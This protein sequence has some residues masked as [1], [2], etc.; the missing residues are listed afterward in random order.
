[1]NLLSGAIVLINC[2][3]SSKY[4]DDIT[5]IRG[6]RIEEHEEVNQKKAVNISIVAFLCSFVIAI[7]GYLRNCIF[8]KMEARVSGVIGFVIFIVIMVLINLF[9][10]EKNSYKL[11]KKFKY[12]KYI[13][14]TKLII[15]TSIIAII[16]NTFLLYK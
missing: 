1:M 13:K 16:I 10:S 4:L 2:I 8:L 9:T 11:R 15:I 3:L 6:I 14:T 12:E 7:F 5:Y